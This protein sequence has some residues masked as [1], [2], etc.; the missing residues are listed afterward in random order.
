MLKTLMEALNRT[1]NKDPNILIKY[2]KL[3]EGLYILVDK[4]TGAYEQFE[5]S[6]KNTQ[7]EHHLF[8]KIKELDMHSRYINSNKSFFDKKISSV[9]YLSLSIKMDN[10]REVKVGNNWN[11]DEALENILRNFEIYKN[12]YL[13][14]K[15]K[16]KA[17]MYKMAEDELGEINKDLFSFFKNWIENNLKD[18][19]KS[20]GDKKL[21]YVKIFLDCDIDEYKKEFRRYL[22]PNILNEPFETEEGEILGVHSLNTNLNIKKPFLV[23]P[24]KKNKFPNVVDIDTAINYFYLDFLINSFANSGK[25][26]VYVGETLQGFTP[27]EVNYTN[28]NNIRPKFFLHVQPDKSGA[29][30]KDFD[31][32]NLDSLDTKIALDFNQD[33]LPGGLNIS[34]KSYLNNLNSKGYG[35]DYLDKYE[36]IN[37]IDAV[38]FFKRLKINLY[39]DPVDLGDYIDEKLNKNAI[40]DLIYENRDAIKDYLYKGVDYSLENNFEEMSMKSLIIIINR[41]K[42]SNISKEAFLVRDTIL[43]YFKGDCYDMNEK[44]KAVDSKL[45][46]IMLMSNISPE[47][48]ISLAN[49]DEYSYLVGQLYYYLTSLSNAKFSN[50]N[51]DSLNNILRYNKTK[52]I[53]NELNKMFRKYNYAIGQNSN[54]FKN[55]FFIC[56]SFE[57]KDK[58]NKDL[59]I[60]GYLAKNLMYRSSKNN[61]EES[62]GSVENGK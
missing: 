25:S 59:V 51:M 45:K 1:I 54:R 14:Y 2:H 26:I 42:V 18:I 58:L 41:F 47:D 40:K 22:I 3:S 11:I 20:I 23:N 24:I 8:H 15:E 7:E 33:I 38:F 29:I 35:L 32:F 6:K 30:I 34:E 9:S 13:K 36:L 12:P 46:N 28:I 48:N 61:N 57:S 49:I 39:N 10:L 53:N 27:R 37:L 19:A 62:K 17:K 16:I 44:I 43:K 21:N 5:V 31:C 60:A 50:L 52:L 56:K 55:L 4:D